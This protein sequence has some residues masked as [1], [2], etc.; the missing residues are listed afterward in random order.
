ML[1][2]DTQK[3]PAFPR[4]SVA[5]NPRAFLTLL[6]ADFKCVQ[7]ESIVASGAQGRLKAAV[8]L[9][10]ANIRSGCALACF[11]C[12]NLHFRRVAN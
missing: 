7:A 6:P 3:N 12:E 1:G 10:I 9:P 8:L 2:A 4:R 5:I 11:A